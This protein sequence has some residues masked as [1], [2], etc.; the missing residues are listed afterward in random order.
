MGSWICRR[1]RAFRIALPDPAAR[2]SRKARVT[3]PIGALAAILILLSSQ[4]GRTQ[5]LGNIKIIVPFPAGGAADILIRILAEEIYRARGVSMLIETRPGAGSVIGTEAAARAVPDGSTLL[6]N[7][8]SFVI[9]PSLRTL[10]YDPLT[11]FVPICHLAST[12]MIA[13][14]QS[15]SPY[16]TL[17]E[18]FDAARSRPGE[19]TLASL[20]PATAQHLA[21]E[22]LKRQ[23]K[24]DINFVPYPGNVPAINTLLGGHVTSSLA[25]YPD[26]IAHIRGGNLRGLATT[27]RTRVDG[28]PDVP[29]VA[30]L[31]FEDFEAE[32]WNG[33][34]APA[35]TP[36]YRISQFISWFT[37]ASAMPDVRLKLAAQGI[38]PT[39]I[40]GAEFG[41]FLSRQRAEYARVIREAN[42]KAE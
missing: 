16:R 42:I 4:S 7:A 41:A 5:N 28:L 8:N 3:A 17:A 6:I 24:A 9:S 21:F 1:L 38:T 32:V 15:S 30:E 40:C 12:P 31:G 22:L 20:G 29:T 13:V 39:M 25:N 27:S 26:V 19:L 10:S 35:N 33:I 14:V 37:A 36:P 18:F 23:A 2:F 11:S 34:V